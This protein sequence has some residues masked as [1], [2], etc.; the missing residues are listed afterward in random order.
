MNDPHYLLRPVNPRFIAF[1]LLAALL[2][3]LLPWGSASWVPDFVAL[4]LL[5][6]NIHESR[7]V[8]IGIAFLMGLVVDVHDAALLGEH[9]LAYTLTAFCAIQL[10]RR[11]LWLTLWSQAAHLWPLLLLAKLVPLLTRLWLGEPGAGVGVFVPS[12]VEALLWPAATWL[13]LAPQRRP[14]DVDDTRPI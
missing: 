14:Q 4:T 8:N 6:W 5:F 1:S 9:A 13:L 12:L 3:H 7:H 10:Q 11:V 2:L